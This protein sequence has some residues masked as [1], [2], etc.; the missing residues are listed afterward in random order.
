[1]VKLK[2]DPSGIY[3]SNIL[4]K[5]TVT[6][7][8]ERVTINRCTTNQKLWDMPPLAEKLETKSECKSILTR[9]IKGNKKFDDWVLKY[10]PHYDYGSQ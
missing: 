2:K 5:N 9:T 1:M 6:G 7:Y 4:A 10:D 3:R 8:E